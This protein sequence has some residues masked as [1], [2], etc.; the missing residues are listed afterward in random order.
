MSHCLPIPIAITVAGSL[1]LG[2]CFESTPVLSSF[3][4][5]LGR[6]ISS[7][8]GGDMTLVSVAKIDGNADDPQ[9]YTVFYNAVVQLNK[10]V[11]WCTFFATRDPGTKEP[12]CRDRKKGNHVTISAIANFEKRGSD[13]ILMCTAGY[14]TAGTDECSF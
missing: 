13:W 1:M 10:D 11:T 3:Q 14:T 5:N 4:I 2:G 9:H 8:T 6:A 12:G 7:R